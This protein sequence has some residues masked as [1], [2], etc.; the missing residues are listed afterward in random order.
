VTAAIRSAGAVLL[1]APHASYRLVPFVRAAQALGLKAVVVVPVNGAV[2]STVLV[3]QSGLLL[4][5]RRPAAAFETI[6]T[7]HR[8]L[9]IQG[10]LGLDDSVLPLAVQIA[11]LLDLPHNSMTAV[12][13]ASRKDL[14][15]ICQRDQG[16]RTPAFVSL[17]LDEREAVVSTWRHYPCVA[18]PVNMAASQG[19]IRADSAADLHLAINRIQRIYKDSGKALQR[20]IIEQYIDGDE[21]AVEAVLQRGDLQI[22]TIFDKP[23][24]M[25][26]PYF[27]ESIYVTPSAL[28]ATQV[29]HVQSL[30]SA[31]C[32]AYGLRTGPVHAECRLNTQGAWL[33]EL[34]PRT[35]GGLCS[36]LFT[37][38]T[39]QNLEQLILTLTVGDEISW[40][41][42]RGA[43]GV[44]MI[45]VTTGG[46]L[47]RVEG[48]S[49][50]RKV[51]GVDEVLIDVREGYELVPWPEGN[52]YP[53]FIF[54]SGNQSA[55]VVRALREAQAHLH[56][57]T[58]P[59]L[60]QGS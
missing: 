9:G 48:L 34:A 31:C 19:V 16:I 42:A 24:S 5:T 15:R 29:A 40:Q 38:G 2:E 60:A 49:A 12:T 39:G 4:D 56:F 41:Q 26:G 46:V 17:E 11:R 58:S 53:G 32:Q 47:R 10:V 45:P 57:V 27:E 50:A 18:K 36:R 22:L 43:R 13:T 25:Q 7:L 6:R 23:D 30:L 52:T 54:A 14:A 8:R 20:V 33:L 55:E 1:L 28:S 51:V 37:M 3:G 21:V 35:I 44:M 59:L